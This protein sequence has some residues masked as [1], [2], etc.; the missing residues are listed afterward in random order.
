M[1]ISGISALSVGTIV[2]VNIMGIR[3]PLTVNQINPVNIRVI[4]AVGYNYE[5]YTI[6]DALYVLSAFSGTPT[7]RTTADLSPLTTSSVVDLSYSMNAPAAQSTTTL[8]T[9]LFQYNPDLWAEDYS[10]FTSKVNSATAVIDPL[11][12]ARAFI[13][14]PSS[15]ASSAST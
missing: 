3:V 11:D 1:R 15:I 14:F 13:T 6:R 12:E 5:Y 8:S 7:S 4:D 9:V 2:K 10:V